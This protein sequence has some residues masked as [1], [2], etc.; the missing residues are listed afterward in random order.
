MM[1]TLLQGMSWVEAKE[2]FEKNETAILPVG[3]NEQHGPA[4]PLGTDHFIAKAIGEELGKRT[5]TV[6]LQVVPF[7]VSG[8]HKQFWGTIF[9][10]PE[11]FKEYIRDVCL[12][13]HYFGVN[14]IVV[15]NGHGGNLPALQE[16]SRELRDDG[17]F[18]SVFE[19]WPAAAKLIPSLFA[20]E[21]RRHACAEETS[22]NLFLRSED[23]DMN[24][25]VDVE[26]KK[27]AAIGEGIFLPLDSVDVTESGVFGKQ[28]SAS[29]EKGRLVF[30]AVVKELCDHVE[31]MKRMKIEDLI[32]QPKV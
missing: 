28:S 13:L 19:W 18:V 1:K 4:N 6:C 22:M 27:H 29:A 21:E 30:E 12:S 8:N 26:L 2:Y 31:K 14:K 9:V 20:V 5:G 25:A 3:S 16:L 32:S 10:S 24:K 23:V 11:V 15:V 17:V 7:G